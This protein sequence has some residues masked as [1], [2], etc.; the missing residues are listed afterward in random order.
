MAGSDQVFIVNKDQMRAISELVA[1]EFVVRCRGFLRQN[2]EE[3]STRSDEYL[4]YLT[5]STIQFGKELNFRKER[6][7]QRLLAMR[8][9]FGITSGTDIPKKELDAITT[10][11]D[12]TARLDHLELLLTD[13]QIK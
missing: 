5:R 10:E 11:T 7:V 9:Q 2:F 6:S 12:E 3:L 13:G 8:Q 4:D 1:N